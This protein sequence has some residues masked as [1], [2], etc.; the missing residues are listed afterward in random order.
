MLKENELIGSIIIY[1]TE[2]SPFTEKQMELV[3]ELRHPGRHRHR[4]HAAAQ[5]A[6]QIPA[7]ADSDRRR[8]QGYQS[9]DI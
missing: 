6:A 1:R 9:L 2:V 7:A 4:E 5:R 3:Q 8:A